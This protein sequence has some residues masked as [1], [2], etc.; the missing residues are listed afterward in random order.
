MNCPSLCLPYLFEKLIIITK[1]GA[2]HASNKLG[3]SSKSVKYLEFW[4]I[5]IKYD[6][7]RSEKNG[8]VSTS[9]PYPA[10]LNTMFRGNNECVLNQED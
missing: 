4:T 8:S 1:P 5:F 2:F 10:V 6:I 7:L 3:P 9:T